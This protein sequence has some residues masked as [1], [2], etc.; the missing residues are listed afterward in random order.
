MRSARRAV[1][2]P[3]PLGEWKPVIFVAVLR[4]NQTTWSMVARGPM[5][6]AMFMAYVEQFL[7]PTLKQND[8]VMLDTFAAHRIHGTQAAIE[9][10][11]A[12]TASSAEVLARPQSH[13]ASLQQLQDAPA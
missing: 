4:Y 12:N 13:R 6:G 5:T 10:A 8:V 3:H 7:A 11:E 2:R 1:N 9:N